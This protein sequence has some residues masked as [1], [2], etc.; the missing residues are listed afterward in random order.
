MSIEDYAMTDV[1]YGLVGKTMAEL[2]AV[3]ERIAILKKQADD[4]GSEL[5]GI[6]GQLTRN[7]EKIWFDSDA[8]DTNFVDRRDYGA[9]RRYK[10]QALDLA[11]V[12]K[13]VSELRSCYTQEYKLCENLK[14][15]GFPQERS[16]RD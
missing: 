9:T 12:V 3:K 5:S 2:K 7:P 14:G 6:G 1:D 13:V 8:I 10:K 4:I 15:M 11:E 16:K